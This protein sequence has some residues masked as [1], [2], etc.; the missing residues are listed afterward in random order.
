M[1]PFGIYLDSVRR[2]SRSH[3]LHRELLRLAEYFR[4]LNKMEAFLVLLPRKSPHFNLCHMKKLTES[5][6]CKSNSTSRANILYIIFFLLYKYYHRCTCPSP[7]K[8]CKRVENTIIPSPPGKTGTQSCSPISGGGEGWDCL[9]QGTSRTSPGYSCTFF[10][11][12]EGV[13]G[14][15]LFHL[16]FTRMTVMDTTVQCNTQSDNEGCKLTSKTM[17]RPSRKYRVCSTGCPGVYRFWRD[18]HGWGLQKIISTRLTLSTF[19]CQR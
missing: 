8:K 11:L 9:S 7:L 15:G 16:P 10:F 3:F 1:A 18:A 13:F 2:Q 19:V 14:P 5:T 4:G 12:G 17:I 6:S